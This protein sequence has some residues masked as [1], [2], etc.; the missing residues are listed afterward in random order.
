MDTEYSYASSDWMKKMKDE[1]KFMKWIIRLWKLF[2]IKNLPKL[3]DIDGIDAEMKNIT[4]DIDTSSNELVIRWRAICSE[5]LWPTIKEVISLYKDGKSNETNEV[6]YDEIDRLLLRSVR[7]FPNTKAFKNR[8]ELLELA[9]KDHQEWRY[10]WSIPNILLCVDGIVNDISP[11]QIWLFA[12]K[13]EHLVIPESIVWYKW[14]LNRL[15]KIYSKS[16]NKTNNDEINM[17]YRNWILHWR[18]IKYYNKLV[19][20]KCLSLLLA[21][22]AWTVDVERE[23]MESKKKSQ[24]NKWLFEMLKDFSNDQKKREYM[25]AK[26]NEW[27]SR[28]PKHI[29]YKKLA[30]GTPEFVLNEIVWL[31]NEKNFWKAASL[32]ASTFWN[33]YES[34]GFHTKEIASR[35]KDIS[36]IS[37]KIK[38]IEDRW[39][40]LSIIDLSLE[41]INDQ[42]EKILKEITQN[43]LYEGD[44]DYFPPRN[45]EWWKWKYVFPIEDWFC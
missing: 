8:V 16:R 27:K 35:L 24:N 26:T 40:S 9:L 29:D 17:P 31:L 30:V 33:R 6:M 4:E 18:D 15:I 5:Y 12:K 2:G 10:H 39:A 7:R 41:Y 36:N 1:L 19:S 23:N 42:W 28:D 34:I 25:K 11:E 3:E 22:H 32:I 43:M 14:W 38:F 13:W 20:Y 37:I 44:N 21:I 45:M